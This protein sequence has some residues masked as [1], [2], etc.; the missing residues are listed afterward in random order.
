MSTSLSVSPRYLLAGVLGLTAAGS[1]GLYEFW[2]DGPVSQSLNE[3]A[4]LQADIAKT[5]HTLDGDVTV[6]R[7][8]RK[9]GEGTLG[10]K[11]DEVKHR[12]TTLLAK[13]AEQTGLSKVVVA[14]EEPIKGMNPL[15]S[16]KAKIQPKVKAILNKEVDFYIMRASLVGFGDFSQVAHTL[17]LLQAQ[18][19]AS[20]ITNVKLEPADADKKTIKLR[21]DV[22]TAWT[23]DLL[24]KEL[25]EPTLTG[26]PAEAEP[27]LAAWTGHNPFRI[28]P[29]AAAPQPPVV[30]A[31]QPTGTQPQPAPLPPPPAPYEQWKVTGVAQGRTGSQAFVLNTRTNETRTLLEGAVLEDAK[32]IGVEGERALFEIAGGKF[33]VAID[34][35]LAARQPVTR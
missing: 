6:R 16:G 25:Q 29:P 5:K 15:V 4:A 2:Y 3:I 27:G 12:L 10:Y 7:D 11:E 21:L 1:W 26:L 8:L 19:W 22:A 18:P 34:S 23:P 14:H 20:Q 35:T 24:T 33:A 30:V 28:E 9:F 31:A 17:A 32:L 13:I